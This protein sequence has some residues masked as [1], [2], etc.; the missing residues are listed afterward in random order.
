MRT[1]SAKGY[2][3]DESENGAH[4][5]KGLLLRFQIFFVGDY[6]IDESVELN[7]PREG[8]K[9]GTGADSLLPNSGGVEQYGNVELGAVEEVGQADHRQQHQ[10]DFN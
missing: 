3:E 9:M 6:Q 2:L 4:H 10:H 7:G 1:T 8:D 5:Q